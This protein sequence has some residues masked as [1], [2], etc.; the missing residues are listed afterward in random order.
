MMVYGDVDVAFW[1]GESV[2]QLEDGR[3]DERKMQDYI[4]H[5]SEGA[6][7]VHAYSSAPVCRESGL[8]R[9]VYRSLGR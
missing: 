1:G 2:S 8:K 5:A 6:V 7:L 3:L 4:G 9:V